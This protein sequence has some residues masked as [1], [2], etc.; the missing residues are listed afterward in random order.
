MRTSYRFKVFFLTAVLAAFLFA[1]C[2][3]NEGGIVSNTADLELMAKENVTGKFLV[4]K[5]VDIINRDDKMMFKPREGYEYEYW[6]E[7]RLEKNH[8]LFVTIAPGEVVLNVKKAVMLVTGET[9]KYLYYVP[10]PVIVTMDYDMYKEGGGAAEC[11]DA[12]DCQE[13]YGAPASPLEWYCY[14]GICVLI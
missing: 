14:N 2:G 1:G 4:L 9:V 6:K 3:K 7:F 8:K 12:E 11:E 10:S 13:R 5:N